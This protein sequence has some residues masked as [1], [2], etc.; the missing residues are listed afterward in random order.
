[1][2]CP[3]MDGSF[4]KTKMKNHH[5]G[6]ECPVKYCPYYKGECLI[7][8]RCLGWEKEDYLKNWG[9]GILLPEKDQKN[10]TKSLAEH[11]SSM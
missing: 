4:K 5:T 10:L 2:G 6:Y 9:G 11:L 7:A 1:M 8:G 3:N